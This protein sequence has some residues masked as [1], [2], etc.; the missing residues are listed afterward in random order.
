MAP[1]RPVCLL[2]ITALLLRTFPHG[3][4]VNQGVE[5]VCAFASTSQYL[6]FIVSRQFG[7]DPAELNKWLPYRRLIEDMLAVLGNM[8][9]LY[10]NPDTG[11]CPT[12][13][14][15]IFCY[16]RYHLGVVPSP[17]RSRSVSVKEGT[18]PYETRVQIVVFLEAHPN[19]LWDLLAA[20]SMGVTMVRLT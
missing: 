6:K 7:L 14:I 15:T 13:L 1:L 3:P 12:S 10:R 8:Y 17:V 18:G 11:D 20:Y 5:G 2:L 9:D 19:E 4:I 16:L